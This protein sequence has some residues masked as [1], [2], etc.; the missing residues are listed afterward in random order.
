MDFE[1]QVSCQVQYFVYL[2]FVDLAVQILWQ[3]QCFVGLEVHISWQVQNLVDLEVQISCQGQFF[4]DLSQLANP[5]P[6]PP[7]TTRH[8]L[9]ETDM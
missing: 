1:V 9:K 3:V 5:P 7:I 2:N 6:S 8:S 4:V